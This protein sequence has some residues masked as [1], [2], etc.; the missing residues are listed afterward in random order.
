[1]RFFFRG[2]RDAKLFKLCR[3]VFCLAIFEEIGI[4]R[5]Q[6]KY[7]ARVLDRTEILLGPRYDL[8]DIGDD[9]G[10]IGA[11]AAV[12]FFEPIEIFEVLPVEHDIVTAANLFDA[13][14]WKASRLIKGDAQV[15]NRQ[16]H[17]HGVDDRPRDQV[18]RT[19]DGKPAEKSCL[20]P[21][22]CFLDVLLEFDAL[23]LDLE[24][25]PALLF[26]DG[27]AQFVFESN[28]LIKQLG[29]TRISHGTPMPRD[30]AVVLYDTRSRIGL[31][32]K[33]ALLDKGI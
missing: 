2:K 16:R 13:I 25:Y 31:D 33:M 14:D 11:I 30:P 32:G 15:N 8:A 20:E 24:K 29:D 26:M 10:A 18:L 1:M 27:R 17:D 5:M 21:R 28:H 3:I 22:V 9:P 6:A 19:I 7:L 23:A 12:E 4:A